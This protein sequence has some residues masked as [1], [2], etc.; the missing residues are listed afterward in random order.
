[1]DR[2]RTRNLIPPIYGLLI[3]AGFLISATVGIIVLIVGGPIT[4]L[5]WSRLSRD[6]NTAADDESRGDRA[7]RSAHRH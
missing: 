7:D 3:L 4:G 5:L 2:H 1:M 6:E